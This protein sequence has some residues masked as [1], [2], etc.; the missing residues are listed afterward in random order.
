MCELTDAA[1]R[2]AAAL[3]V[4]C[5]YGMRG[6]GVY[7]AVAGLVGANP[8]RR[9]VYDLQEI[10]WELREEKEYVRKIIEDFDLFV[11]EDGYL[12]DAFAQTPEIKER[13]LQ[14]EK[15]RRRSE[16]AKRGAATRKARAQAASNP[17]QTP[18]VVETEEVAAQPVAEPTPVAAVTLPVPVQTPA[19]P[20]DEDNAYVRPNYAVPDSYFQSD[21]N[22]D[23]KKFYERFEN[24]RSYWNNLFIDSNR[25][26][27]AYM[28][29]PSSMM[30]E[31]L[32]ETFSLYT[33]EQIKKAFD[34]A[35][36]Q[37]FLWEF[38]FTI[39]PK[40]IRKLL[41]EKEQAEWKMVNEL[42]YEQRE[43]MQYA[44]DQNLM[45]LKDEEKGREIQWLT[46]TEKN[47]MQQWLSDK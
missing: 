44:Q 41:S 37:E 26:M 2:Y 30:I 11:I 20:I 23:W 13:E 28:V 3:R 47:Q 15:R 12:I 10:C 40:N 7:N 45:N 38:R 31:Y 21:A 8:K 6:F 14:E 27:R 17:T 9:I 24:I 32:K 35:A 5:N 42:T 46:K 29:D 33:D 19:N 1:T 16:A 22:Y 43:L 36:E 4:R 39:K 18:T 25:P 34:Y